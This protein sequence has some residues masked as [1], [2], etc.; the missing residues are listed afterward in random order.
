[1]S[2]LQKLAAQLGCTVEDDREN[3]TLY[4]HAPDG[5]GWDKGELTTLVH[6]YGSH[7][8]YLPQWRQDAITDATQRLAEMG[9]PESDSDQD[10]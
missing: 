4:V 1:M 2:K 10:R 8:S 9:S 5:K 3:T 6:G 7:G